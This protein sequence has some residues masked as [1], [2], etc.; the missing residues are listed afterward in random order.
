MLFSVM[1]MLILF[2]RIVYGLDIFGMIPIDY[3]SHSIRAQRKPLLY[4]LLSTPCICRCCVKE[5]TSPRR[6]NAVGTKRQPSHHHHHPDFLFPPIS[7]GGGREKGL[8]WRDGGGLSNR[9]AGHLLDLACVDPTQC[10]TTP[11][12]SHIFIVPWLPQAS[13]H[14]LSRQAA[15]A[16][17]PCDLFAPPQAGGGGFGGPACA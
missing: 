13:L 2:G 1:C 16:R 15:L 7:G 5:G 4:T 9:K 12:V 6:Q 3:A 8:W 17:Q 11:C 14:S 10:R